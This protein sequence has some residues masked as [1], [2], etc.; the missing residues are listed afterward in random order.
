ML[1][2]KAAPDGIVATEAV[3]K[4]SPANTEELNDGDDRAAEDR[5]FLVVEDEQLREKTISCS[6][7]EPRLSWFAPHHQLF[8]SA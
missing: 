7:A 4:C 1:G 8:P 5:E 6:P 3:A 2:E